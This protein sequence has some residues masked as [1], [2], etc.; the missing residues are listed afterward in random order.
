MTVHDQK[1]HTRSIYIDVEQ[2]WLLERAAASVDGH[3]SRAQCGAFFL[4]RYSVAGGGVRFDSFT[5]PIYP[6][7]QRGNHVLGKI[8][9]FKDNIRANATIVPGDCRTSL[10]RPR[11]LIP[12]TCSSMVSRFL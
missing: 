4:G 10:G 6:Q 1:H 3:Q 9:A 2:S 8:F 7:L 11:G 12:S 5:Y